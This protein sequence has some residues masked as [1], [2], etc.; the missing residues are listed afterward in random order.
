MTHQIGKNARPAVIGSGSWAT[1]L[2]KILLE[3]NPRV[4]WHI[5]RPESLEYILQHKTNPRYLREVHFD[6]DRLDLS[7][8]INQT[9]AG[10]DLIILATPSIHLRQTLDELTTPLD[11]KFIVSAIKG[12]IPEENLTITEYI[13]RR[14]ALPAGQL[15]VLTGPCHAEEVALERLSYLTVCCRDAGNARLIGER[16]AAPYIRVNASTDLYGAEYAAVLKNVY[17]I[18]AGVAVG[19]GYGD[20]YLSVLISNAAGELVRF[21][22]ANNPVERNPFASACLGDLLVTAYS[23]F[24][25]NRRL[26]LMIGKGYPVAAAQ[27]EMGMVAEGYGGAA[28]LHTINQRTRIDMPIAEAVYEMLY[29]GANPEKTVE[30]L[31]KKLI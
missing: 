15:G 17:A 1:A 9:V 8:D 29:N 7:T 31:S 4:G 23:Q 26:G 22:Q 16:I 20:N 14:F 11:G 30:A 18:G 12:I 2:V 21:L 6:T 5:R 27:M 10:A 25:R 3:N 19:L 13:H 28:C 24:S